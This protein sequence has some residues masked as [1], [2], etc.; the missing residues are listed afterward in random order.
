MPLLFIIMFINMIGFGM[1]FPLFPLLKLKFLLSDLAIG[2]IVSYSALA[3]LVGGLLFGYISDKIG[4]KYL[5]A[6]PL[7]SMGIIYFITGRT[8]SFEVFFTLR[9]LTGLMLGNFAIVFACASDLS[10][11]ENKFKNMGLIG[12]SFGLGFIFGPALG[13]FFAGNSNDLSKINFTTPFDVAALLCILAGI[14]TI[15]LFKETLSK[16]DRKIKNT[17]NIFN[18]I[19]NIFQSPEFIFLSSITIIF[20]V[21]TSGMQVFLGIFLNGELNYT[22]KDIGIYWGIYGFLM[23]VCQIVLTRYFTGRTALIYGFIIYGISIGLLTYS[24]SLAFLIAS[25]IGM[26]VGFSMI[27]PNINGNLALQGEKNQQGTIFGINQGFGSI[28]RVFGPNVFAFL[29]YFNHDI[30]WLLIATLCVLTSLIV[31]SHMKIKY[32]KS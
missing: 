17:H 27:G 14:I 29:Y 32:K 20:N 18:Q 25:T 3:T 8:D 13:G 7:L 28:G 21:I 6:L 2:Y 15:V 26:V 30:V 11:K 9:V 12:S 19:K 16:T 5:L 31:Y 10:N 24:S 4:R 22:P 1:I 23:A